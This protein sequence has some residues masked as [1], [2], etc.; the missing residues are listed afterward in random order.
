[1]PEPEPDTC[2]TA[3]NT[4]LPL[5]PASELGELAQAHLS[6]KGARPEGGFQTP[7]K[8]LP[9]E[10]QVQ[11]LWPIGAQSPCRNQVTSS[12]ASQ[13]APNWSLLCQRSDGD[14]RGQA[15]GPR[16]HPTRVNPGGTACNA[17][18]SWQTE[19]VSYNVFRWLLAQ[20]DLCG[21]KGKCSK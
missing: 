20:W 11:L 17:L 13:P 2:P 1:M 3:R 7:A 15:S 16:G 8:R 9:E 10:R 14:G 12:G 6:L 19:F 5:L 18:A 4:L 21:A